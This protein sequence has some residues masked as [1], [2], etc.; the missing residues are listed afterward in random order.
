MFRVSRYL[1]AITRSGDQSTAQPADGSEG[2]G[3]VR[4][5]PSRR[6]PHTG[7]PVVIWNLIRRC[8]LTCKHCYA[9][10]ADIDFDGELST[11]EIF[12]VMDDLKSF[13]VSVLILSG[14]EPM[15]HPDIFPIAARAKSMG[16]YVGLST[17]GTLINDHNIAHLAELDLDYV[18]VSLDGLEATHDRFRRRTGAFREALAG[19]R[20]CLQYDIKV[21]LRFTLTADNEADLT[22]LLSLMRCEGIDKFYLSHLNYAGRGNKNR[23][24]DARH[25]MTR[26]SMDLLIEHCLEDILAARN[27]EI[28]TGNNDADGV[29]LYHWVRRHMPDKAPQLRRLLESWGGNSSGVNIS[30]IDNLGNVHPDTM[31]WDY[32]VGNVRQRPFS[33]IW[34]DTSD[35]LMAGLKSAVRPLKGRCA[36]CRYRPICG[37]NSRTRAWQLTGDPW[38]EDPGCYLTDDE[39]GV[40]GLPPRLPLKPRAREYRRIQPPTLGRP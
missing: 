22:G 7:G 37:G 30:N 6:G 17:N 14:G 25:V 12:D 1:R 16:F 39:I 21:G 38:A 23:M 27:S 18:G 40:S 28:V 15:M 33:E 9:T 34:R 24:S 13:G 32:T 10:S 36:A 35:P 20:S 11:A 2:H 26:K 8:N 29:Y 19:I 5:D 4:P 31:W 3:P